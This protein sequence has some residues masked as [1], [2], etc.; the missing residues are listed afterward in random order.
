V[1]ETRVVIG[2][3]KIAKAFRNTIRGIAV[4][5]LQWLMQNHPGLFGTIAEGIRN[6]YKI[7]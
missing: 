3:Y 1:F 4:F 7:T 6:K 5:S 2:S